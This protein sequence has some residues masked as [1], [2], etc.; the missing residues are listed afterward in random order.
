M[1][2]YCIANWKMNLTNSQSVKFIKDLQRN[3]LQNNKTKIILCPSY[4]SINDV[5]NKIIDNSIELGAQNVHQNSEGSYTGEISVAMLRDIECEWVIL[6]HS[7]RRQ[8][9]NEEDVIIND[10]I[11]I[12]IKNGLNPILCI[13]ESLEQRNKN[14]TFSILSHQ[15]D[16]CLKDITPNNSNFLI[17]Y[18]PIWAIG[19]GESATISQIREVA[20]WINEYLL[21]KFS[22]NIP[23]LYGGSVSKTNC[24]DI[25][26]LEN[27]NGFLIGTSSLDVSEFYNIYSIMNER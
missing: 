18:E 12:V 17:A 15:L 1:N 8:Y 11:N 26:Q 13:G 27:I 14:E 21:Q 2:Y 24:D 16:L 10:K 9:Y 19:A 20:D 23:I 22:I 7:E 4:L 5:R 3:S 6:G 25:I